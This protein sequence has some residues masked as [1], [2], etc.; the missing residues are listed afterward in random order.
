MSCA[1]SAFLVYGSKAYGSVKLMAARLVAVQLQLRR[2]FLQQ[3]RGCEIGQA[4]TR[5]LAGGLDCD[6]RQRV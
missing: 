6:R 2:V 5:T 1:R 4:V 3:E